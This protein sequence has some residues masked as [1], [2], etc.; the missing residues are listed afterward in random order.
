[1]LQEM[2]NSDMKAISMYYE[3]YEW[4]AFIDGGVGGSGSNDKQ[5]Q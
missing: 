1:M 3:Q 2:F 4:R 5:R